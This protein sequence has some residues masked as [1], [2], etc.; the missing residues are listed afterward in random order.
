MKK[1]GK[2]SSF[3]SLHLFQEVSRKNGGIIF[4]E[5]G[6]DR[7][8][9][10]SRQAS[11]KYRSSMKQKHDTCIMF[12]ENKHY[13]LLPKFRLFTMMNKKYAASDISRYLHIY[14]RAKRRT[15]IFF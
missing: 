3:F 4:E 7:K 15:E 14:L 9:K 12:S 6:E 5:V 11:K 2:I 13:K 10:K 8:K 1:K